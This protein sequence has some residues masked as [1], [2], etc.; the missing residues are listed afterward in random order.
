[1]DTRIIVLFVGHCVTCTAQEKRNSILLNQNREHASKYW[2]ETQRLRAQMRQQREMTRK[3]RDGDPAPAA[4][5][6]QEQPQSSALNP[7]VVPLSSPDITFTMY[8]K[9]CVPQVSLND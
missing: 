1:M 3:N 4:P 5:W 8:M 9:P 2:L 7:A 6:I